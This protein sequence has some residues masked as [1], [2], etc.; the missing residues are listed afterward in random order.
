M[1]RWM[2]VIVT[3]FGREKREI[4]WIWRPH[5]ICRT[6]KIWEDALRSRNRNLIVDLPHKDFEHFSRHC[7]V[8]NMRSLHKSVLRTTHSP[9]MSRRNVAFVSGP[10]LESTY[11]RERINVERG[12]NGF[13]DSKCDF[14]E[15][16]DLVDL[17]YVHVLQLYHISRSSS[18]FF[19]AHNLRSF[20]TALLRLSSLTEDWQHVQK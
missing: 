16:R 11:I 6:R 8:E 14:G 12:K 5:M 20:H 10:C 4:W 1:W 15:G 19:L 7:Y 17:D 13:L 9:P 2:M 3:Y 18:N